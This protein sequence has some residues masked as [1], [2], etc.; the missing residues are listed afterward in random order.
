MNQIITLI[1]SQIMFTEPEN[2][3]PKLDVSQSKKK[4]KTDTHQSSVY[5]PTSADHLH[6]VWPERR[7]GRTNGAVLRNNLD[8]TRSSF[9]LCSLLFL[10]KCQ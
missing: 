1:Y 9:H 7:S 4:K 3:T 6:P 2:E 5:P 8:S 10:M